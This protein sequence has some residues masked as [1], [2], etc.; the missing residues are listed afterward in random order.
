LS[1]FSLQRPGLQASLSGS[2]IEA[3]NSMSVISRCSIGTNWFLEKTKS[4]IISMFFAE[5]I[6][7]SSTYPHSHAYVL[8]FKLI[9][10]F[11]P[12]FGHHLVVGIHL[13]RT[14]VYGN[15]LSFALTSPKQLCCTCLLNSPLCQLAI[16][17][18]YITIVEYCF[19]LLTILFALS[20][21]RFE[22]LRYSLW[23]RLI[24]LYLLL[25]PL[26]LRN[27]SL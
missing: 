7:L 6:S 20:F 16:Y 1:I 27:I 13:S 22:S 24:V 4:L 3:L 5:C 9:L 19:S 2:P 18:S 12:H 17:S 15:A 23:I 25:D 8:S 21:F 11:L 10:C 26:T 14:I